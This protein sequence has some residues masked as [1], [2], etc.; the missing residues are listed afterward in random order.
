MFLF[1]DWEGSPVYYYCPCED[2]LLLRR[3]FC[4]D[5]TLRLVESC[6]DQLNFRNL[7]LLITSLKI[8][9]SGCSVWLYNSLVREEKVS[10]EMSPGPFKHLPF[11]HDRDQYSHGTLDAAERFCCLLFCALS[12][13][14]VLGTDLRPHDL[15][16]LLVPS[17][18]YTVFQNCVALVELTQVNSS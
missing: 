10:S 11:L 17:V 4:L 15:V 12:C 18:S 3:G 6:S 14:W 9:I 7:W 16:F 8:F 1:T 13:L 5:V 2:L